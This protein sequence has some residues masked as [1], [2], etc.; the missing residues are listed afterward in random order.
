M[1][2][3]NQSNYKYIIIIYIEVFCLYL[4]CILVVFWLYIYDG[5]TPELQRRR[6]AFLR[7]VNLIV[8]DNIDE[9]EKEMIL[10]VVIYDKSNS[11]RK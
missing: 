5:T 3:L 9:K 2:I 4:F 8:N 1:I 10:Y 6:K 11:Y 7:K